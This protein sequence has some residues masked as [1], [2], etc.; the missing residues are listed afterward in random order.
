MVEKWWNMTP[1]RK[2]LLLAAVGI[3]V[4]LGYYGIRPLFFT[5]SYP[6]DFQIVFKYG[7][8]A[9]NILNT[10]AGTYTKDLIL[11]PSV[12]INLTFTERE[13]DTIW[14][15][16]Q[17]NEFYT[18]EEQS[19]PRA[20]AVQPE[21]KYSLH[22]RAEGYPDRELTMTYLGFNTEPNEE[23]FY[24]IATKIREFIEAKP[25]YKK[26]PAPRGGYA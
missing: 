3:V 26:L 18:I 16:I 21:Y 14:R 7:V 23:A 10:S 19:P 17:E 2:L 6:D 12:T 24:M 22:I 15:F 5:P 9:R 8:G 4:I 1:R 20:S 11:D 13:M 25:A